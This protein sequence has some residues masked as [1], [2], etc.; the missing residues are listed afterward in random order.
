MEKLGLSN[1]QMMAITEQA[2]NGIPV[3]N[4]LREHGISHADFCKW[5]VQY[6]NM[7]ASLVA[8]LKELEDE[9]Q[10]LKQSEKMAGAEEMI[11]A[12]IIRKALE[13]WR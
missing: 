10:R 8:R 12:D 4:L 13:S 2:D 5:R 6:G 3:A 7:E 9:N 1:S 11:K